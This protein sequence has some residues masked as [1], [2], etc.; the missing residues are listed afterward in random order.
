[1]FGARRYW[2][3]EDRRNSL[4]AYSCTKCQSLARAGARHEQHKLVACRRRVRVDGD[5]R[6]VELR[7]MFGRRA[8]RERLL[9][10][11][12]FRSTGGGRRAAARRLCSCPFASLNSVQCITYASSASF[13]LRVGSSWSSWRRSLRALFRS[14]VDHYYSGFNI[15]V[16]KLFRNWRPEM[17][18]GD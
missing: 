1:M 15:L 13:S 2:R 16:I 5:A 6:G 10:G 4:C 7:G 3:R 9:V 18:S 11:A 17:G 12:Q 14:E 8:V